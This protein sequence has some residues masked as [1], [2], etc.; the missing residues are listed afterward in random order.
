M[1][2]IEE[3]IDD[4]VAFLN[5]YAHNDYVSPEIF[6]VVITDKLNLSTNE[7]VEFIKNNK[8]VLTDKQIKE[9]LDRKFESEQPDL[10][11][12]IESKV[13]RKSILDLSEEELKNLSKEEFNDGLSALK[14]EFD[15]NALKYFKKYVDI[16]KFKILKLL[17]L[18]NF[19]KMNKL[20]QYENVGA[21]NINKIL[22][23][24]G[25]KMNEDGDLYYQGFINLLKPLIYNV[26]KL[27]TVLELANNLDT[28][29]FFYMCTNC[30]S[31]RG[32]SG[33]EIYPT[34]ELQIQDYSNDRMP[35]NIPLS[36]EQRNR[37]H[38][39]YMKKFLTLKETMNTEISNQ[40]VKTDLNQ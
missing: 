29:I 23:H 28:Y 32:F 15:P 27:N 9:Y 14:Y 12:R 37:L 13:N 33:E 38:Q 24:Y 39:N 40:Y 21:K 16:L 34:L 26:Q 25:I 3:K 19:A 35:G 11:K 8:I 31:E 36:F 10:K 1:S 6:E 4:F 18:I 7:I 30:L 17:D 5:K 22:L 2:T 20:K